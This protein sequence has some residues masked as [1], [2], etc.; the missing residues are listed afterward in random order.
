MLVVY[1]FKVDNYA[2]AVV[3]A[4]PGSKPAGVG[5]LSDRKWYYIVGSLSLLSPSKRLDMT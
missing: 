4:I 3:L 2:G 5:I 1:P